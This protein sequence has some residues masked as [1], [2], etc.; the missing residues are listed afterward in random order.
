MHLP[1][2]RIARGASFWTISGPVV[3]GQSL[4]TRAVSENLATGYPER[5]PALLSIGLLHTSLGGDAE[6]E[7]NAPCGLDELIARG[8]DYV[9]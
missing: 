8:Y 7:R 9:A 2:L 6:H 3:H 4:A 1:S 5:T